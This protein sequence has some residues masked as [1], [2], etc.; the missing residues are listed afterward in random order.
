MFVR[1]GVVVSSASDLKAAAECEWA[2]M[3]KLDA[4]LHRIEAVPEPEDA[5]NRRA[6]RLGDRHEERQLQAYV[7]E[8]GEHV[9]GSAGG[10]AQI[11]R[12]EDSTDFVALEA[13]REATLEAMRDGADVVFQATLFDGTFLG[14]A[15]FLVRVG[16]EWEVYDTKLARRAKVTA[17]LQ[18]AAYAEQLEARGIA[19]GPTVHLLLGDGT[20][21]HHRLEDIRPVFRQRMAR[22]RSLIDARMQDEQAIEWSAAGIAACGRCA[23]CKAQV[24]R[25]RDVLLVGRLNVNQRARLAAVGITTID[26][27]AESSGP[28][29]GI[30]TATLDRLRL[31]AQLQLRV[32]GDEPEGTHHVE[33]EVIDP[34][35]LAAL[36]EP[37]RG[38]IFFDFEGDPLWSEDGKTWGLE[39]LFGVIDHDGKREHF[40]PFWAHD[41]RRRSRRCSTS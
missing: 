38:D 19:V 9:P 27:L 2:L 31:Q 20:P 35:G 23:E 28:V 5:M 3:R 6:A 25:T 36:P 40:R 30:G 8:F 21:S 12:P 4:K 32:E 10:V 24:D 14:F 1:H 18:L 15:D 29:D 39:Y 13:A 16:D 26:E 22:L 37:D 34:E 33:F 11:E 7:D 17:L 41:G